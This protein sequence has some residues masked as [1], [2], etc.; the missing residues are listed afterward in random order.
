M[1]QSYDC[2]F[3]IISHLLRVACVIACRYKKSSVWR[4]EFVEYLTTCFSTKIHFK[5]LLYNKLPR[6]KNFDIF[7]TLSC[8]ILS[9]YC[10]HSVRYSIHNM[11]AV[12]TYINIFGFYFYIS[13]LI[14]IKR[15]SSSIS[16]VSL[17]K[18]PFNLSIPKFMKLHFS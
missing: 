1:F 8:E 15:Q 4:K 10:M 2:T 7:Y 17:N 12:W 13:V 18:K 6:L 3:F 5:S 9:D 11:P 16:F 14:L